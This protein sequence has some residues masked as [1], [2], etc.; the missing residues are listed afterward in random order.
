M[1]GSSGAVYLTPAGTK[2]CLLATDFATG[3]NDI[4]V[5]ASNDFYVGDKVKFSETGGATLDSGLDTTSVYR[6][7]DVTGV[8]V[9]IVKD[10]D[11]SAVTI[12][13]DGVDNGGHVE[14]F[15]S[16]AV[17]CCEVREWSIDYQRDQLD[18]SVLPCTVSATAGSRKWA[19]GKRKTPGLYEC[20]GTMTLYITDNSN[21]ISTRIMRS[22]HLN[23]Q[24]GSTAKLYWDAVSDGAT[25]PAP[26]DSA[27]RFVAGEISFIS[28]GGGVN[29][30][31]PATAEVGFEMYNITRWIDTDC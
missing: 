5:E 6:I 27:S 2:A 15:F 20:T 13:G 12:A 25:P 24:E 11:G 18:T 1:T 17:A 19:Q 14:M 16:P 23:S 21:A 31:D 30:D 22:V 3:D 4:T 28:F 26:D 29:P 10:S 7:T 9:T 8:K